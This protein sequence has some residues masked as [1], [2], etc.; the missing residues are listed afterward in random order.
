MA[1]ADDY[2]QCLSQAGITVDVSV[3]PDSDTL[4]QGLGQLATWLNSLDSA[5]QAAFDEV[6]ADQPVKAGLADPTVGIAPNLGA[7]LQA[8]DQLQASISISSLLATCQSCL[9]Q[10][11]GQA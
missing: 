7:L 5:T 1:F 6:T 4:S 2:V 10:V 8:V 9:Q 3:I 11:T